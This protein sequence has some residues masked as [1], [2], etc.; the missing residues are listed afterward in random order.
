VVPAAALAAGYS[1]RF[2]TLAAAAEDVFARR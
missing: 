1:Y 2:P